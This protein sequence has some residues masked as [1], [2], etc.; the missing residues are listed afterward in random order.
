MKRSFAVVALSAA[1][2]GVCACAA[3]STPKN[4]DSSST[5]GKSPSAVPGV[6]PTKATVTIDVNKP[7]A[8]IPGTFY[9]LMTE[10]INHSYDGG[11]YAE[12]VQNRTFQDNKRD[13]RHWSVVGSGKMEMDRTDPVNGALPVSLRLE[14]EGAVR[15][16]G[17][18][19]VLGDSGAAGDDVHG[20]VLCEGGSGYAGP[21]TAAIMLDDGQQI[22]AS[23]KTE[24]VGGNWKKYTVMLT[25]GHDAPTTGEG[26]V[27]CVGSGRGDVVV[28][29]WCRCF[30][31]RTRIMRMGCG[32]P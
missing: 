26:E 4:H 14:M 17:E 25:T 21:V 10:E 12:L 27:F 9:G 5:A 18:R 29:Q 22:V 30:R 8:A 32:R 20:V 16:R 19:G 6:E 28:Q 24:A 13:L 7:G 2:V 1:V 3:T 11:L 31:R 23:G 15:S